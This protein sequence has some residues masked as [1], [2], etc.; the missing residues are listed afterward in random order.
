LVRFNGE[1]IALSEGT[2]ADGRD[3]LKGEDFGRHGAFVELEDNMIE[4]LITEFQC[5][6][7]DYSAWEFEPVVE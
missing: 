7:W 1:H 3:R 4:F 5:E 2:C 6:F